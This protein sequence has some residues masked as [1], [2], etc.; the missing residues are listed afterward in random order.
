MNNAHKKSSPLAWRLSKDNYKFVNS[1]GNVKG[2]IESF[3]IVY[4]APQG[5]ENNVPY[6]LALISLS[7]GEKEVSEIVDCKGVSIGDNVE[8]CLRRIYTD[9]EG[10]IIHYGTKYRVVK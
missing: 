7:N 6:I 9:G 10:G 8:P 2:V 1:A 3:T 5:Y 4:S